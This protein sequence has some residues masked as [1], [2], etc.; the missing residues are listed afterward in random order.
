MNKDLL[1]NVGQA[2]SQKARTGQLTSNVP[3]LIPPRY[4]AS[5]RAALRRSMKSTQSKK[6]PETGVFKA[7]ETYCTLAPS[8]ARAQSVDGYLRR[9]AVKVKVPGCHDRP[10][11]W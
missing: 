7:G 6:S 8:V 9:A 4:K 5:R 1:L 2:L 3:G 11:E 10:W